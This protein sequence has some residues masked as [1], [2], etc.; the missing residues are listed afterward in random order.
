MTPRVPKEYLEA[1]RKQILDAAWKSFSEKG[2]H[3]ATMKDIFD[4]SQLSPGAVYNYFTGKDDIVE[5]FSEISTGRNK[6][7]IGSAASDSE[8]PLWSVMEA[9]FAW[10]KKVSAQQD[11]VKYAALDLELFAEASRNKRIADATRNNFETNLGMAEEIIKA[12]QESGRVNKKLAPRSVA[13]VLFVL[14]QGVEI[15]AT[16]YPDMDVEEYILVCRSILKGDLIK[17][18]GRNR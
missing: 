7:I 11:F 1:R 10:I 5:A 8:D 2:F 16:I 14:I 3:K 12:R 18:E 9:Y 6:D 15:L 13:L 4:A 17:E